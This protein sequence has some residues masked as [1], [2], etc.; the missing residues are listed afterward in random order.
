MATCLNCGH[1]SLR[2]SVIFCSYLCESEY[3]AY[4]DSAWW[5]PAE[6]DGCFF[7]GK[8]LNQLMEERIEEEEQKDLWAIYD[9]ADVFTEEFLLAR[10]LPIEVHQAGKK[11]RDGGQKRFLQVQSDFEE[12]ARGPNERKFLKR[13]ASKARRRLSNQAILDMAA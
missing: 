10:S 2:I 13:Q 6:L 7:G 5:E 1:G 4:Q 8:T 12:F 9:E 3:H 11:F